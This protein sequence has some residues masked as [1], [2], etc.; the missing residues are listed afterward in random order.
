MVIVYCVKKIFRMNKKQK[1][2]NEQRL[3]LTHK[4]M[5]VSSSSQKI[6]IES[7]GLSH[8]EYLCRYIFVSTK[9]NQRLIQNLIQKYKTFETTAYIFSRKAQNSLCCVIFVKLQNLQNTTL[10]LHYQEQ[11]YLFMG[12]LNPFLFETHGKN[13][14]VPTQLKT[15]RMEKHMKDI[16]NHECLSNI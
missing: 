2:E 14:G 9:Y 8:F 5:I 13:V 1:K 7:R 12:M 6:T 3:S 15:V 11:S 16:I 4:N 10:N